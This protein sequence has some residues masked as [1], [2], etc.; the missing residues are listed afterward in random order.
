MEKPTAVIITD[1]RL[2]TKK[3]PACS[4]ARDRRNV[5]YARPIKRMFFPGGNDSGMNN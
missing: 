1:I 3:I 4:R 5:S 2:S